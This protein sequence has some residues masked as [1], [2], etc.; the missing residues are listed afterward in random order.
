[1]CWVVSPSWSRKR[2]FGVEAI[3]GSSA[4]SSSRLWCSGSGLVVFAFG[5]FP[6]MIFVESVRL[7]SSSRVSFV[8]LG[9]AERLVLGA[10][11]LGRASAGRGGFRVRGG[12]ISV[13]RVSEGVA[14]GFRRV[15]RRGGES[16]SSS[17]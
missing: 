16:W 17:R 14:G 2:V 6:R 8:A 7:A 9:F 3:R 10:W 13:R 5:Y 4:S 12:C 15:S 1:M 11:V